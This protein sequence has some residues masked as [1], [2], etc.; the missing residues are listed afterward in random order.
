MSKVLTTEFDSSKRCNR[1]DVILGASNWNEIS[2]AYIS[3]KKKN[4]LCIRC[5]MRSSHQG[6]NTITKQDII[7]FLKSQDDLIQ[8]VCMS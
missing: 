1:C 8:E 4:F 3:N 6:K 5:A 7:K 2:I